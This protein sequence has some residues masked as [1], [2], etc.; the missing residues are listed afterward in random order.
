[1]NPEEIVRMTVGQLKQKPVTFFDYR[2]GSLEK[3]II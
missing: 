1:M 2:T 3:T